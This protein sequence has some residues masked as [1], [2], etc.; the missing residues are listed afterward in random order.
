MKKL[1]FIVFALLL[2][3]LGTIPGY[4]QGPIKSLIEKRNETKEQRLA[5]GRPFLS[6]MAGPGYTPESGLLIGGGFLYTFKTNRQDS[7]IERSNVPLTLFYSAKGNV[8]ISSKI[9]TF[10]FEDRLRIK[11]PVKYSDAQD[12]Y[13]GVG[14][15]TVNGKFPSD[16]TTQ[17]HRRSI[18]F[19]PEVL[20]RIM[21]G[22][23]GGLKWDFEN[24]SISEVNPVMAADPSYLRYGSDIKSSGIGFLLTYDTRDVTVNAYS[25]IY[26]GLSST[27]FRS[28]LG[29]DYD[30]E[31]FEGDF[32]SYFQIDH[33]GNTIAVQ[34]KTRIGTGDMPYNK[35]SLLGGDGGLRGYIAGQYRDK[36][37][38]FLLT[39][40]R[41]M[42]TN[43]D[44]SAKPSGIVLWL[45]SG[46]IGPAINDI[47]SWIPNFG[48][49]YRFEVQPRMN[50]RIDFGIGRES[51]GLYFNI[52]ESF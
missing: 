26:V 30:F 14:F 12:D 51:N 7:L 45:G 34:L 3:L 4:A 18:E 39:E 31:V 20:V 6:M 8:G 23:Y 38:V 42:F 50:V 1:P 9:S 15:D 46:G 21:E 25:G 47:H 2:I 48:I 29:S 17:Y 33:P 36:S 27:M 11:S 40:W 32:R 44:G 13:F 22:F 16:S 35:M 24:E 37:S 49:G 5:E 41:H 10:W 28:G 52:N 43:A 19:A